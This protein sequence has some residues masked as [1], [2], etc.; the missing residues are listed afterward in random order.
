MRVLTAVVVMAGLWPLGLWTQEVD[1]AKAEAQVELNFCAEEDWKTQDEELNAA[2]KLAM[3]VM[4]EIDAG[5]PEDQR[6]AASYLRQAQ[7]DWI[8]FRDN[9]CAA[10]G[11]LMRGG[12]AEPMLIYGCLARLTQE[13]ALGLYALTEGGG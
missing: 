13:R 10:E 9:A 11:F 2:Y 1:C 5:L 6:G 3:A 8:A 7:R 4:K 12:S